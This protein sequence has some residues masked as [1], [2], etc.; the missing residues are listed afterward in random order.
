MYP[1]QVELIVDGQYGITSLHPALKVG[2]S[3]W[4]A[5]PG[6]VTLLIGILTSP[7]RYS[8]LSLSNFWAQLRYLPA[9]SR[10]VPE[11]RLRR[12]WGDTDSHQ[13]TLLSDD[14]GMGLPALYMV[15]QLGV[16]QIVDT[17]WFAGKFDPSLL[18]KA[19]KKKG[20]AKA[21]DFVCTDRAGDFHLLECKGTQDSRAKLGQQIATGVTQKQP[22]ATAKTL[23]RSRM[24]GGVFVPQFK[25]REMP[26]LS[27]VDPDEDPL[28]AALRE[29]DR[30]DLHYAVQRIWLSKLLA[31]AGLWRMATA[32]YDGR[33]QDRD[34]AFLSRPQGELEFV[35]YQ[36]GDE[37]FRFAV[38]HRSFDETEDGEVPMRNRLEMT[39]APATVAGLSGFAADGGLG[40][41]EFDS[42][43]A[44]LAG[45]RRPLVDGP[46]R[47]RIRL[48]SEGSASTLNTSY[49]IGFRVSSQHYD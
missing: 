3:T 8:G 15:E 49:G 2:S 24:V 6:L 9:L 25:A 12:L 32:V 10:R 33:V 20:P 40:S 1:R 17:R 37:G 16:E 11:L 22:P 35:G 39:L 18:E 41:D 48:T 42:W 45:A 44:E 5:S 47:S 7:P 28:W 14:F 23:F 21:A 31:A 19:P 36:R 13:K 46:R 30:A 34:R 26:C 29:R 38:E 27:F 43:L 4:L